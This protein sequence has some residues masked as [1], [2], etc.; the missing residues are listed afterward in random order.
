[1]P[2]N[3]WHIVV[4]I[5]RFYGYVSK[6]VESIILLKSSG[7]RTCKVFGSVDSRIVVEWLYGRIGGHV[8][9]FE[10]CYQS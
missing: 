3:S 4:C 9:R 5:D 10:D 2:S 6:P 1:M 8:R 7:P